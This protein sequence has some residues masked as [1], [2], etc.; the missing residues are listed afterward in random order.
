MIAVGCS[1]IFG[2]WCEAPDKKT[3]TVLESVVLLSFFDSITS[4]LTVCQSRGRHV[5][6]KKYLYSSF[7]DS[8]TSTVTVCQY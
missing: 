2:G 4:S 6:E 8:S 7:F 3:V 1:A 5:L